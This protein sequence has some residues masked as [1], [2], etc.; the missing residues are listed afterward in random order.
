MVTAFVLFVS[1]PIVAYALATGIY[2][3]A[4]SRR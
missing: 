3:A 2:L 4:E 1:V